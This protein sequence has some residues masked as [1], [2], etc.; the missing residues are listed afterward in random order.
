LINQDY[1][2]KLQKKLTKRNVFSIIL[3]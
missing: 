3:E 1:V 2:T